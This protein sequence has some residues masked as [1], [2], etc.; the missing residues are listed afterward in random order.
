MIR[1]LSGG[2]CPDEAIRLYVGMLR[3]GAW[4]NK[5]TFPFVIKGCAESSMVRCGMMVHAHVV[6][7][8][9][10]AD[11]YVHSSLVHM[12]ASGQMLDAARKLFDGCSEGSVSVVSWNSMIDGYVKC[13]DLE[14]AREVFDGMGCRDVASWNTMIN[15]Y[16]TVGG[17]EGAAKLFDVM[18]ERN[19]I[20]WNSMLAAYSK[21]GDVEG[22]TKTFRD[23]PWKDVVSWNAMLDCYA[24]SG[25]SNEALALFREMEAA[26]VRPTDATIV[27]LLSACAH[28]GALDQGKKIHGYIDEHDIVVNTV[29]ATALVDMYA[30]CGCI[31]SAI[32]VFNSM[33]QKDVLAWNT[34]IAAMAMYGHAKE[35]L[36]LF[37]NMQDSG[38]RPDD[39][40]FVS[41]L[42]ACSHVGMVEEGRRLLN[43]MGSTHGMEPRLEHYGCVVDLLARAGM[44]EEAQKL[45]ETMPVEPNANAWGALLGGCRIH[46]RTDV[47]EHA[48]RRLLNLQ[49][50]HSGR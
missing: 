25:R 36:K 50:E 12:Y 47:G 24:N 30:K 44:L 20:S 19:L 7:L 39:I 23:M 28:L 6:V 49:P 21:C 1:A 37:N 18:P 32:D 33:E 42:S 41:V 5:F 8:G 17:L 29:L 43:S 13:G 16:A 48:G 27:S 15:G 14:K 9:L 4:P 3:K 22:A 46:G 31:A 45:I 2:K 10:G 40:S 11:P 38:I 26:D 34:I 35:A